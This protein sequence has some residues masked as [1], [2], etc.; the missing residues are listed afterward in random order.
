MTP[1]EGFYIGAL[2]M[3]EQLHKP[4]CRPIEPESVPPHIREGMEPS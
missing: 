2:D 1:T 3:I 4:G